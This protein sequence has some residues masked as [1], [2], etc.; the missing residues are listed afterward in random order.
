MGRTTNRSAISNWCSVAGTI[1]NRKSLSKVLFKTLFKL[2]PI[3][4]ELVHNKISRK[5]NCHPRD[6]LWTLYFLKSTDHS[7]IALALRTTT[8]TLKTVVQNT[9]RKVINVSPTVCYQC[10]FRT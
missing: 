2:D 5:H 1:L 6:L 3:L 7:K 8:R 9:M 4:V 10:Y